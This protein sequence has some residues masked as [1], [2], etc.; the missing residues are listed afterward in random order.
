MFVEKVINSIKNRL[1]AF[2][3]V[4]HLK[5]YANY[6]YHKAFGR[7]INWDNPTEFNEK[8]YWMMFHSDTSLW[9]NLADKYKVKEILKEKGYGE[10]V[11]KLYGHWENAED[12]NFDQL[13]NSFVLKTNHGYGDIC[14][15]QDKSIINI[16][17]IKTKMNKAVRHRHGLNS[18]ELHYLHIKPCI[19]AEELLVNT[20]S[21]SSSLVDYKF[22]CFNGIPISCGVFFNRNLSTH[23]R[24]AMYYDMDWEKRPEWLNPHKVAATVDVPKPVN[25]EKMKQ[26]CRD[27]C[28]DI[29]FVR[30]DL[31][32]VNGNIYFG[33]YTFTPASCSGGSLNPS[34]LRRYGDLIVLNNK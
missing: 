13:P 28:K 8:I 10:I 31:Y 26:L 7:D 32:E 25:F 33:E 5:W 29:P 2:Y 15:V 21:F 30:L 18:V 11:T 34:L 22:Y 12:I 3:G 14:V 6:K 19:I 17:H 23:K 27:L 20:A 9:S 16:E 1:I 24:M 4:R